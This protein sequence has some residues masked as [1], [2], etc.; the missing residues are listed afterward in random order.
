MKKLVVVINGKGGVGKDTLCKIAAEKY[1]V[2]VISSITPIKNIARQFGWNGEKDEKS[3]R[4]LSEL[5]RV[6]I[7][8]NNLP[9]NYLVDE[10]KK[11]L[12]DEN[13]I[14]FVHIRENNQID[15]FKKSIDGKCVTLLVRRKQK[16]ML[17]YG[18]YS[19]D[20][21]E[22]YQYDYY[23]DNSVSLEETRKNFIELIDQILINEE[24]I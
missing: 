15:L 13:I 3:R 17:E 16:G 8:Y 10:Y 20:F 2:S 21:V 24:I 9:N 22:D 23:Y 7:E 5:K 14:L 18:N 1:N 6:F 12:K 11:F 19:D 4:F